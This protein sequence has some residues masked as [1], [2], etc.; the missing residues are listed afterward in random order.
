MYD[1]DEGNIRYTVMHSPGTY[2]RTSFGLIFTSR[3]LVRSL[4]AKRTRKSIYG[5][6]QCQRTVTHNTDTAAEEQK[7]VLVE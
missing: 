2:E 3:L 7:L 1:S 5:V 4:Q 6:C